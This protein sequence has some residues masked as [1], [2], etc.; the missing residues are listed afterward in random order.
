MRLRWHLSNKNSQV[1]KHKNNKPKIELIIEAPCNDK[2]S[3]EKVENE[4]ISEYGKRV[5]NIT[6]NP[7]TVIQ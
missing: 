2:K 4:Y 7:S 6:C 3:L 1:F 5:L